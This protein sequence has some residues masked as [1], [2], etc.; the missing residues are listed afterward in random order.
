MSAKIRYYAD[1]PWATEAIFTQ[2]STRLRKKSKLKPDAMLQIEMKTK[3][4]EMF[5]AP[6]FHFEHKTGD[7]GQGFRKALLLTQLA[8]RR[9]YLAIQACRKSK[10]KELE[11]KLEKTTLWFASLDGTAFRLGALRGRYSEKS[12]QIKCELSPAVENRDAIDTT[13]S[14]NATFD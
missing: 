2:V 7:D 4:S 13:F 6:L 8:W 14:T 9:L 12:K 1:S 10:V 3:L 11:K 5:Y